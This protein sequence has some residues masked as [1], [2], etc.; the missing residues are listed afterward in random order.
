M[1]LQRGMVPY[2]AGFERNS[3]WPFR[4][5]FLGEGYHE[6]PSK[7]KTLGHWPPYAMACLTPR[8]TAHHQPTAESRDPSSGVSVEMLLSKLLASDETHTLRASAVESGLRTLVLLLL[9]PFHLVSGEFV[10]KEGIP[11]IPAV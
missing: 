3:Y 11:H 9:Q 2:M 5:Q 10:L 8:W 6:L 1:T 7:N 4:I